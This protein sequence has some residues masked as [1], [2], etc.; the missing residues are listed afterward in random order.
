MLEKSFGL[1]FFLKKRNKQNLL[2]EQHLYF[3]VTVDGIA[4]DVSAKR[5]WFSSLWCSELSRATGGGE[6]AKSINSLIETL[7]VKVHQ[8]RKLLLDDNRKVTADKIKDI[9][10][11]RTHKQLG[12][13][14][15]FKEHNRKVEALVGIDYAL[16]TLNRYQ[17][18]LDH[19]KAYIQWKYQVDDLD[20]GQLDYEFVSDFEF[21]LKTAR[22][23]RHNTSMKYIANFKKIVLICVKRGLLPRDPFYAFRLGKMEVERF[24]LTDK[25]LLGFRGISLDTECLSQV[26]DVFLFCCY[27]GLAYADVRKLRQSDIVEGVDD[28]LWIKIRRQKTGVLSRIPL[29][30]HA[31]DI[32][33]KYADWRSNRTEGQ[34]FPVLSN[35]KMNLHL[36]EIAGLCGINKSVTCHLAR[37]TFATT[38]TLTNGVPLDTVSKMLGHKNIQTTQQYAKTIDKKIAHDMAVLVTALK[39]KEGGCH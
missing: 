38:V 33:Q 17:T 18:T 22:K 36:K 30:P 15:V 10:L 14:D 7:T 23:C 5:L 31:L 11:G 16:G 26:R 4:R 21:W 8:A 19:T 9:L 37:H 39:L 27:T 35:Q 28:G 34:V 2:G 6:Q 29:L 1:I 25:E 24:A 13:L 32:M 3:R 12:I 20:V